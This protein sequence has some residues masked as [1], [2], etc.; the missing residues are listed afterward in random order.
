MK[1][2]IFIRSIS[3]AQAK[4]IPF[5]IIKG[6]E[7]VDIQYE[8]GYNTIRN[9]S[10]CLRREV[11]QMAS[12]IEV[13]MSLW[14]NNGIW[15]A[16]GSY[17]DPYTHKRKRLSK[18]L[19]LYVKQN[20]KRKALSMLPIIQ[21]QWEDKLNTKTVSYDPLFSE[22]VMQ[23]LEAKGKTVKDNSMSGYR[24]Y[25]KNHIIPLL[26]GTKTKDITYHQL[27]EYCDTMAKHLKPETIGKHFS[28][29]SGV[30]NDA[31]RDGIITS[32]PAPL[33][34]LPRAK[35]KFK[36]DSLT[37]QQ[38]KALLK[39]AES[40][41]EPILSAIMLAVVYGLRRSE[42]CGLRWQD[43]DFDANKMHICN[44]VVKSD[45]GYIEEEK[46]KTA[47]SDRVIALI[48]FTVPYL[49]SL[50]EKQRKAGLK[51][52]KVCRW[53]NG[54]DIKS[55]YISH[56]FKQVLSDNHLPK[57]RFHDLRHTAATLLVNN[58]AT[59]QQTQ[60]FLGHENVGTTMNIYTHCLNDAKIKTSEIMNEIYFS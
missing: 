54:N 47:K 23:W 59:P 13:K 8:D 4:V 55:D 46:T 49:K 29:I 45:N 15:T 18:T 31:I 10:A 43:I 7:A 20:T 5:S 19:K 27:Q 60:E 58:G 17:Y 24:S 56:K 53:S 50:K 48:G 22:S 9:D 34:T 40:E 35:D 41:G 25:A 42:I 32:N 21:A 14:N 3:A 2:M 28:L 44:T 57:I 26:G 11:N 30:L 16:R 52:G 33:V 6:T 12:P 37:V 36:G 1:G 39:A 51:L 38:A